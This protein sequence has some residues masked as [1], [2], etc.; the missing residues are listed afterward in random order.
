MVPAP[1]DNPVVAPSHGSGPVRVGRLAPVN[2]RTAWTVYIV[3]RLA[4][5]AV[6]FAALMLIGWPWWLAAITATLAAVS[7]SVIFLSKPRESAAESIYTWRNRDRTVDDIAEDA[8]IAEA[9]ST[10]T[11]AE[12][13]GPD[14]ADL[15]STDLNS[16]DFNS[17]ERNSTER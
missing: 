7:L 2:T 9:E 11:V 3:L 14:S 5:F 4:F 16:T 1:P 8:A 6:P 10:G 12:D 13:P 15:N 17:T